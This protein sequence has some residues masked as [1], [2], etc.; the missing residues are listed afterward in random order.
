MRVEWGSKRW[1]G[2]LVAVMLLVTVDV[3]VDGPLRRLDFAVH[4]FCD[5]HITG[6][7]HTAAHVITKLGQRGEL[8]A[9]MVPLAVIAGI[10]RRS[11]RHPLM[12]ALIVA[13]M[14]MLQVPL[15]AAV[16]RSFPFSDVDILAGGDAYPSG[17]TLNAIVFGWV[18]LE[19]LVAAFPA[20]RPKLPPRRRRTIAVATGVIA[21]VAL[22]LAD[23]HWLTDCLFSLALGPILLHGLII[24]DPFADRRR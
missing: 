5:T 15:K 4:E 20:V 24:F 11:W 12:A 3:L 21:A 8:V 17:H 22:T 19:L 18:I 16:P 10:R 23:E 6:G 14:S 9:V 2:L 7:F 13:G 1:Y